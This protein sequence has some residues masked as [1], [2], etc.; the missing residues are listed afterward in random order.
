MAKSKTEQRGRQPGGGK[1]GPHGRPA[2]RARAIEARKAAEAVERRRKLHSSLAFGVVLLLAVGGIGGGVWWS[3]THKSDDR[4]LPTAPVAAGVTAPPWLA[5]TDPTAGIQL[6]GLRANQVET[7]G[8]HFHAHLDIL[9]NGNKV[10]VPGGIGNGQ[11]AG[12]P[13]ISEI[14]THSV[15]GILHVEA[16]DKTRRYVLG[17][18]FAEWGIKLDATH[19]GSFTDGNGKT[20]VAYINGKKFDGN[21]A[22]IELKEHRQI[23]LIFGTPDQQ[24]NPPATFDWAANKV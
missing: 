2:Q 11:S 7:F 14:H 1:G 21:P 19:L 22:Q 3:T 12:R 16:P 6:S 15:D 24:K 4:K 18:L 10:D 20:L 13:V 5:P 23:A 8:E 9:A 17:E